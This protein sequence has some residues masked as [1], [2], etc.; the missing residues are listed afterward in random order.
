MIFVA[1]LFGDTCFLIGLKDKSDQHHTEAIKIWK[2]LLSTNVVT[3]LNH[4]TI[5]DFVL[6]EVFQGLQSHAGFETAAAV[7]SELTDNCRVQKV[8]LPMVQQAINQKL[9]PY[10]NHRT[11]QPPIG[12]V[13]AISLVTMDKLKISWILSFDEGFDR[14]PLVRRIHN[15]NT[16]PFNKS[17]R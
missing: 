4:V 8:T 1:T 12:L 7:Y 17:V 14:I 11:K 2:R 5:S 6:I 9:E 15:E 10:R 3:G 13:D 16:L